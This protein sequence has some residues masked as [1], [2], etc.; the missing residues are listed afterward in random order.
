M[1]VFKLVRAGVVDVGVEFR[2]VLGIF[3]AGYHQ[4]VSDSSVVSLLFPARS[5]NA[6]NT[7]KI[8]LDMG[9]RHS[10][11]CGGNLFQLLAQQSNP[12]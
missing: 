6:N 2:V 7:L 1:D 11:C 10:C 4:G 12:L 9:S 8:A 5:A 3:R